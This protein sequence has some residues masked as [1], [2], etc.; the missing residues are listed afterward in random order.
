MKLSQVD[1]IDFHN[2]AVLARMD[3]DVEVV[4]N[5][6]QVTSGI[7][8]RLEVELP[9]LEYILEKKPKK[10]VLIGHKGRP[11]GKESEELSLKPI[12]DLIKRRLGAEEVLEVRENLR[13]DLR[14]E[15]NDEEF[16]K[17]LAEGID[18]Y[19]NEAFASSHREHAS[20]V[21]VPKFVGQKCVGLRFAQEIENLSKVLNNPKKPVISILSGVKKDKIGYL[22]GFKK[23]SDKVLVGGRLPEYLGEDYSDPKV[24]V[25][26]LMQ[27]KEDITINSI[28]TFEREIRKAGTIVVAGP[29]G[30]FEEE[31]HRLGTERILKAVANSKGY[32]LAGGGETSVA[33]EMF[34]IG[35]YFDW[36]SV[37]GGAMLEFLSKGTLPGIQA[38]LE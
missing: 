3:L 27:D 33:I 11:K 7:D 28:E 9:T 23:F 19:V 38:L 10:I 35:K 25:A 22:T 32:K 16:A 2:K 24:Q 15:Q 31:G 14:E 29:L 13:F 4:S 34:G 5:K 8:Q 17:E 20:I 30:K 6:L 12:G 21:G 1:E 36:I 26:R 18:I 37:G